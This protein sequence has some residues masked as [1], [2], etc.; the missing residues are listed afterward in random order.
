MGVQRICYTFEAPACFCSAVIF[1]LQP[2][3]EL[4][5]FSIYLF[6]LVVTAT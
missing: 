6:H 4:E 3:A 5:A 1:N 2:A